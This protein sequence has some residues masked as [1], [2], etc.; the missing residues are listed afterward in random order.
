MRN[1]IDEL[2][3]LRARC[4]ELK[5][6]LDRH[7]KENHESLIRIANVNYYIDRLL[8]SRKDTSLQPVLKTNLVVVRIPPCDDIDDIHSHTPSQMPYCSAPIF[9]PP[10]N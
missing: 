1:N 5:T 3:K 4:I 8:E 2:A 9:S 6:T 10:A 7:L